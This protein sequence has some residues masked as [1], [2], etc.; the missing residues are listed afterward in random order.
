[1][2]A[3]AREHLKNRLVEHHQFIRTHGEDMPDIRD[4]EWGRAGR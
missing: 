3:Y 2:S 1:M 4:W